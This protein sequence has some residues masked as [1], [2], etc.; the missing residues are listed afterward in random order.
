VLLAGI[1]YRAA[2]R[3]STL[4]SFDFAQDKRIR[5]ED[6]LSVAG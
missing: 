5:I 4:L 2:E 3:L 6:N 1:R